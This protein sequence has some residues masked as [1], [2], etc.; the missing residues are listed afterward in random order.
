M[1]DPGLAIISHRLILSMS[2]IIRRVFH[3]I[4]GRQRVC[5]AGNQ[6]YTRRITRLLRAPLC[7]TYINGHMAENCLRSYQLVGRNLKSDRSLHWSNS[8]EP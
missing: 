1:I 4:T 2:T 5:K 3:R 6:T 8:C 7:E